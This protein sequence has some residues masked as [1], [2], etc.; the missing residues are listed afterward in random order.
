VCLA[1]SGSGLGL[2]QG[3][4]EPSPAELAQ[5]GPVTRVG[6][7]EAFSLHDHHLGARPPGCKRWRF[8]RPAGKSRRMHGFSFRQ[9]L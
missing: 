5:I 4:C 6:A 1:T 9:T 2:G 8:S 3:I 7:A